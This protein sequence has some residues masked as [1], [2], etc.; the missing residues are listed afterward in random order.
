VRRALAPCAFFVLAGAVAAAAAPLAGEIDT[1]VFLIGDAGV[2]RPGDPVLAALGREVRSDPRH[3]LV[4]FLGDNIYPRG[5]PPPTA[6]DRKEGERRLDA[7]VEASR[8]PGATVIF[9]PG[10][11]DWDG[12]G[13]GGWDAIRRQEAYLDAAGGVELAPR[14]GCPGPVVQ[15]VHSRVRLVVLDTQWWLQKGPKPVGPGSTCPA[16]T[17]EDV[18]RAVGAALIGAGD[19]RLVVVGHHPFAS[20]G[21]HAGH[22]SWRDHLFPLVSWKKW[23]W[24]PLPIVGSAYP[25]ARKAGVSD[26][27]FSGDGYERMRRA[28]EGAFAASPPLVYA[29]GHE[30]ALQ[31]LRGGVARYQVVSGAGAHGHLSSVGRTKGTL[32]AASTSGYVRLDVDEGGRVRLTVVTVDRAGHASEAFAA[33]L[34]P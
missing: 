34:A 9:I 30:H 13:R 26:Q 12:Y 28:L 3:A 11:H 14:G 18:T 10:N 6:P 23:F 5:L 32:F 1:R 2:P 4:V 27:D 33:D 15:D 29:S 20:G 31:V 24:L 25:I 22:F 16:R 7:Q 17:E 21:P 8:A 19:R